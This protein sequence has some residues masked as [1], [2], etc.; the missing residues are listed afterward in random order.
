MQDLLTIQFNT[1]RRPWP[2]IRSILEQVGHGDLAREEIGFYSVT[3]L[4]NAPEVERLRTALAKEGL[5]WLES[6]E[7]LY[8]DSELATFPLLR[9]LA[10]REG[11]RGGATYGTQYDLS[12]ACPVCGTGAIQ[13][14]PLV[15]NTS[16]IP[17]NVEIFQ[18]TDHEI[19]VSSRLERVLTDAILK[20]LRLETAMSLDGATLPWLQLLSDMEMPPADP[21]STGIVRERPCPYCHRDGYFDTAKEP[22]ELMYDHAS[23]SSDSIPDA[24]HT[25]EHF[26]NSRIRQPFSESHFAQPLLLISPAVFHLFRRENVDGLRFD[27]VTIRSSLWE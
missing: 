13:T 18:T 2:V 26:G 5:T 8:T 9:L 25:H 4:R 17:P 10:T 12:R 11:G 19:L 14:S 3:F 23:I 27:P 20:G 15:L 21:G 22:F 6:R 7:R 24:A 1:R 16:E